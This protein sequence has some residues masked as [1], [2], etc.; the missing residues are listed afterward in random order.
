L[1]SVRDIEPGE[2]INFDY[3]PLFDG[4]VKLEP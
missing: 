1:E 2:E 4:G 3:G